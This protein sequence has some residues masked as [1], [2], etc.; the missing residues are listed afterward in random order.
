MMETPSQPIPSDPPQRGIRRS[1]HV[2]TKTLIV[3]ALVAT[4]FTAFTPSFF[5]TA[6]RDRMA[7]L[8]TPQSDNVDA[9]VT[10]RPKIKIG[11]VSGHWGNDSGAVCENG[12]TEAD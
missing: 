12:T 5:S 3:A 2:L 7:V 9:P 4:L 11:I 1:A 10:P 8:L 6:L